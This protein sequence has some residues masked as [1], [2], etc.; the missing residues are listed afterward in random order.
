MTRARW[1]GRAQGFTLIE[2]MIVVVVLGILVALA[3]PSYREHIV[4][5]NREAVKT[6]LIELAGLQEK[7]FLNSDAYSSSVTAAYNGT[8][9]GGLGRTAAVAGSGKYDLSLVAAGQSYTLT[10]TPV[11][12]STQEGDGSLSIASDGR[13]MW[14]AKAW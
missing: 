2:V 5:S 10:A 4:R 1:R 9:A 11:A 7:I 6:E 12:G 14:G 3:Y 13:R 8:A